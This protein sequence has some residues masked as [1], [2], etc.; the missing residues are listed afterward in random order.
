MRGG[1]DAGG[2][3]TTT[4]DG[5]LAGVGVVGVAGLAGA[6]VGAGSGLGSAGTAAPASSVTMVATHRDGAAGGDRDRRDGAGNRGR[7]FNGRLV[8]LYFEQRLVCRDRVTDGDEDAHD[9]SLL[10]AFT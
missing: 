4:G 9:L 1:T 10:D 7:H 5:A 6:G 3:D 8:G 2:G